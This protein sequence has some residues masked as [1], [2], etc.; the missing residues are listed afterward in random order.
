MNKAIRNLGLIALL[1]FT[2]TE[3]DKESSAVNPQGLLD[4]VPANQYYSSEILNTKNL[5]LYG[6]WKPVKTSGGIGGTGYKIDFDYLIIKPYGVFGLV[7]ADS[8]ATYGSIAIFKQTDTEFSIDF[9]S[10]TDPE[11]VGIQMVTDT[12]KYIQ[13]HNDTLELVAFC[14]DRFNTQLVKVK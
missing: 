8:L 2:C 1:L 4:S 11:K 6:T 10:D 5:A 14:C 13:I 12:E 9:V 7:R 3:C